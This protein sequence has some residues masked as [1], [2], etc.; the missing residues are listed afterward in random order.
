MFKTMGK[1][2]HSLAFTVFPAEVPGMRQLAELT[3][4]SPKF[5]AMLGIA[6]RE[7]RQDQRLA[8]TVRVGFE[9]RDSRWSVVSRPSST[10]PW[11]HGPVGMVS[12]L[13]VRARSVRQAR[14]A[15]SAPQGGGT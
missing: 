11:I 6:V 9:A 12:T 2:P 4:R 14:R 1:R 3:K 8:R 5:S 15:R 13:T 7:L 10:D